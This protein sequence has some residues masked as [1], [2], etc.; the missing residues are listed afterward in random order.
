VALV[1][2]ALRPLMRPTLARRFPPIATAW[3]LLGRRDELRFWRD[4]IADGR[5]EGDDHE[6]M[7]TTHFELEP[8]FY[9]GK[10]VLDVGCGPRRRLDWARMAAQRVGLDPL[11]PQYRELLGD[12]AEDGVTYVAGVAERMPFGDASFDVVCS[13]NSLD[14]VQDV[15]RSAAEITRVIA[16][17][18][19]FLL[20]TDVA[21]RPRLMEP[22][23]F[24]WEVAALF[25]P[26]LE[27]VFERRY[28][29]LK[30][31]MDRSLEA[32]IP[33]DETRGRHPGVLVA[34]FEKS[35]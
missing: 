2:R 28:E 25:E 30:G 1:R 9:A 15:E 23:T 18:G 33:H 11:V 14:H 17:G 29:A 12:G 27:L 16:P 19:S 34:R 24:S 31:K 26:E 7:F 32:A 10:R 4:A 8:G 22:Q 35:R 13:F 3:R 5:F 20:A 6:P 21:H